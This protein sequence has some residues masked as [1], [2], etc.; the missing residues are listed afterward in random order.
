MASYDLC[1]SRLTASRRRARNCSPSEHHGRLRLVVKRL[2][3]ALVLL[4]LCWPAAAAE[5]FPVALVN[6]DRLFKNYQP[7][8][9]KLA[10]VREAVQEL[11]KTLQLRS[12]ELETVASQLRKTQ[13]G[14]ADFSRLQQQAAKL[15]ADLQ[16]FVNQERAAHQKREAGVILAFHRDL[17]LVIRRYAKD[18]GIKLVLRQQDN[19]LDENQSLQDIVKAVNRGILYEEDLDI[20]DEILVALDARAKQER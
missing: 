5:P 4:L 19:S 11:E 8:L 12:T 2:G 18:H 6:M 7:L 3:A 14:T 1:S 17:D 10:P 16:Q 20:T 15:Q 9:D 13:P